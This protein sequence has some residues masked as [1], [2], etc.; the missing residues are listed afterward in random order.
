MWGTKT[1]H[2]SLLQ[3]PLKQ[4]CAKLQNGSNV[5]LGLGSISAQTQSFKLH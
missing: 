5:T 3:L 2:L 4:T 1:N